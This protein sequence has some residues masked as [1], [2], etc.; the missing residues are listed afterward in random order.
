MTTDRGRRQWIRL[1]VMRFPRTV[2]IE[3]STRGA[4]VGRV[5]KLVEQG[6]DAAGLP[7]DGGR[8][9]RL[10]LA[11]EV[12][13]REIHSYNELSDAELW[14]LFQWARLGKVAIAEMATWLGVNYGEQLSLEEANH[15]AQA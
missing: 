6:A 10:R 3:S 9:I 2:H 4:Y 15:V 12:Y 8:A 11:S 1:R 13:D 7:I 5:S 14:A